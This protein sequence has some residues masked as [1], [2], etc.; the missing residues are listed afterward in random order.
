MSEDFQLAWIVYTASTLVL[1]LAGWWFMRNW[2]WSWLRR[3]L[4]LIF[5]AV[6]LVPVKVPVAESVAMPVLPLFVYQMLFEENGAA[7]EVTAN[8]VFSAGGALAVMV[9]GGL[10]PCCCAFG[11]IDAV[12]LMMTHTLMSSNR[13]RPDFFS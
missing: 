2:R 7:P 3:T 13:Q 4:L 5:A 11:A 9:F 8:L 6:L 10:S 1:L 12:A